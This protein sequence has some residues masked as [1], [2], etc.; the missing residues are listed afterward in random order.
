MT[1]SMADLRSLGERFDSRP[2]HS[3]SLPARVYIQPDYFKFE[4]E[5]IFH[6]SWQ[7][8]CQAEQLR[9]PGDYI[10]F[11]IQ[12]QPIVAMRDKAGELRAFYNVCRHR[13][14]E[15]IKGQGSNLQSLVCPYH[16][17]S[18]HLDG[19][20]YAAR[21]SQSM[22]NFHF[23]DFGLIPVKIE[24]FC[25]MI[26]ANLDPQATSLAV[27]SGDLAREVESYAPYIY[28]LTHARSL[29][30]RIKANWKVVI[31]NFLECY[32]CT[33]AHKDFVDLV[34]V[35][36]YKVIT[37]DIYSSQI[38]P[39]GKQSNSAYNIDGG[40]VQNFVTWWLWPNTVLSNFPGTR[41]WMVWKIIPVEAE[42]TFETLDIFFEEP[43]PSSQELEAIEYIDKV[44][45]KEDIDIIESVQ[46][47]MNT[48]AYEQGRF[49]CD[50]NNGGQ[51]EHGVHHF[52]SLYL[53]MVNQYLQLNLGIS[54]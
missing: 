30:Y 6:K 1:V 41:N 40:V 46:R 20:L 3:Y 49:A 14:H 27:Q 5:A 11:D 52:H 4:Q 18:Y 26:F 8:V 28:S 47:G 23:D 25:S 13:G 54:K 31:D 39:A 50:L 45:Q 9:K 42:A 35:D 21:N 24:E 10:A 38:A 2:Q 48:P 51:S 15:L 29:T 7:Y 53:K 17:W 43:T 22:E 44:L 12:G 32:H 37:H 19:K 16:A 33:T 36:N 34:D